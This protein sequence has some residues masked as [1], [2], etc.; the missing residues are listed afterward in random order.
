LPEVTNLARRH[1]AA[2]QPATEAGRRPEVVLVAR[3]VTL[4]SC[5]DL[6]KTW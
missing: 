6:E 2:V 3:Q 1:R 5:A 4:D